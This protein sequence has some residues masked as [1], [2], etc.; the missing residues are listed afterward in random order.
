VCSGVTGNLA[1][2]ADRTIFSER[3]MVNRGAV[4]CRPAVSRYRLLLLVLVL[5]LIT[6]LAAGCGPSKSSNNPKPSQST[7]Q[8]G[9]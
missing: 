1:V 9:Y 7:S 8:V 5:A 2:I 3:K 6:S 4:L